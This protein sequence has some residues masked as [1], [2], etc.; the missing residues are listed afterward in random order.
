MFNSFELKGRTADWVSCLSRWVEIL[1][2][3]TFKE[4]KTGKE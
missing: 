3:L 1:L 2:P 4:L